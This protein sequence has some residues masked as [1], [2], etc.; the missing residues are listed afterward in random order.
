M[1]DALFGEIAIEHL[2]DEE[3]ARRGVLGEEE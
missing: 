3:A 2:D 1:Q